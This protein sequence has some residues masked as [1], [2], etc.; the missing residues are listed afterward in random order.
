MAVLFCETGRACRGRVIAFSVGVI[1][2]EN[3]AG[4]RRLPVRL[5][6]RSTD[7]QQLSGLLRVRYRRFPTQT[8]RH[9]FKNRLAPVASAPDDLLLRL[10]VRITDH[11]KRERDQCK[12]Q[13]HSI[14]PCAFRVVYERKCASFCASA[15][16]PRLSRDATVPIEH[17]SVAAICSYDKSSKY[18]STSAIRSFGFN[19]FSAA[20]TDSDISSRA[21]RSS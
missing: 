3:H 16:C 2:V 8:L 18:F 15:L 1:N 5:I 10:S 12:K 14:P 7:L 21:S 6:D 9:S 19:C 20:S 4:R 17:P 11:Q 13:F